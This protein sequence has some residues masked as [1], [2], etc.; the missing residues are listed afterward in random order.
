MCDLDPLVEAACLAQVLSSPTR[1][2]LVKLVQA[3]ELC[4][5]ELAFLLGVSQPAVSQHLAKLRAAGL[6]VERREGT[7]SL[8][9][10]ADVGSRV[11][12]AVVDMLAADPR[13][14][15]ALEGCLARLDEARLKRL[16]ARSA[17]DADAR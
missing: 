16:A 10:A 13:S 3:E 14:M 4:V 11:G 5:C 2:R 6:V 7:L 9:K 15:P 12:R 8:Y 1:L 17:V